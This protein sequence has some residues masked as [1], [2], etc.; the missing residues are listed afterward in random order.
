[1]DIQEEEHIEVYGPE[2]SGKQ[3]LTLLLKRRTK[4]A[5]KTPTTSCHGA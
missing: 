4:N 1:M 2:S 5:Q 3:L